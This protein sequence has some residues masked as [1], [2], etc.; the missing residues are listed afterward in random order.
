M[1][2][3][4][5]A[6]R[7]H[8]EAL[9]PLAVAELRQHDHTPEQLVAMAARSGKELGHLGDAVQ[10]PGRHSGE[11]LGALLTGIAVAELVTPGTARQMLAI[12]GRGH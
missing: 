3:D 8:L 11:A 9:L 12:L 4:L 10:W 6:L 5:G 1:T 2:A 7:I